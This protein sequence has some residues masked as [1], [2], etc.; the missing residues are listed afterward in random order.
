LLRSYSRKGRGP[1]EFTVP[2][3][4]ALVD[5]HH[6]AVADWQTEQVQWLDLSSGKATRNVLT[7]GLPY[8]MVTRHD[9]LFLGTLGRG[10]RRTSAGAVP[11]QV[12]SVMRFGRVPPEYAE[13]PGVRTMHPYVS[14]A[15]SGRHLITGFTGSNILFDSTSGNALR[16]FAVPS[17]RRRP[18]PNSRGMIERFNGQLSDSLVAGMG[19]TLVG[20][21]GAGQDSLL[22]VHLDVIL[23]KQLLTADAWVSMVDLAHD[24]GCVDTRIRTSKAGKPIFTTVGD[25]LIML[26]QRLTSSNRPETWVVRYGVGTKGCDWMPLLPPDSAR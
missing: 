1:G 16:A 11:P 7:A 22:L 17:T 10:S 2:G 26:E 6:L 4:M 14:F 18:M 5:E 23:S 24:R 20:A 19:S 13:S 21:F 9:T 8:T 25:T 12:D 15:S 3:A